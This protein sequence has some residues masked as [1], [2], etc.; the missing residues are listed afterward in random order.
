MSRPVFA[1][2][3]FALLAAGVSPA[4][5][6]RIAFFE[7]KIRPAL[8]EHCLACHSAKLAE[9]M[10]GLRLDSREA[11]LRGG[12]NGPALVAGKPEQSLIVKA[13][14]YKEP[15]LKMPPTGKLPD[16][17]I[18][19]F[20]Y[21]I[22]RGAS[23]PRA[24]EPRERAAR[25]SG[26]GTPIEE[27]RSWWAFQPLREYAAPQT[28]RLGWSRRKID[29]FVLAK[30]EEN[31]L[32]PSPEVDRRTLIRRASF[33]LTGLKP[34]YEEVELFAADESP[35]AYAKLIERLLASP[36]YGERWGR[37]WLDVARWAKITRP[38]N[39]PTSRIPTPG[40]TAI[41]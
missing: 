10:G 18:E 31:G 37:H 23:D 6:E 1:A 39:R 36:R 12:A 38:A 3:C 24:G 26:P 34:T 33:D 8:E 30:L 28:R 19:D 13:L 22:A 27:G 7:K 14:G 29:A 20:R 9:P 17:V 4:Q 15:T 21:W 35:D 11:V 41:G 2:V 40:V 5:D 25:P 16:R 32:Q